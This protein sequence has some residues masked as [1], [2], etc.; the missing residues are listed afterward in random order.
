MQ[1]SRNTLLSFLAVGVASRQ[2]DNFNRNVFSG[3][4]LCTPGNIVM[5]F[6]KPLCKTL[7]H[8]TILSNSAETMEVKK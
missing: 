5:F 6:N 1:I 4:V 7:L 8:G 3:S 2:R